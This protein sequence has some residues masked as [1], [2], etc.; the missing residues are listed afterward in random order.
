LDRK[1]RPAVD[2]RRVASQNCLSPLFLSCHNRTMR[3]LSLSVCSVAFTAWSLFT[4]AAVSAPVTFN[5]DIA[6]II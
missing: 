1:T 3:I 6:P 2:N 5:K 4:L